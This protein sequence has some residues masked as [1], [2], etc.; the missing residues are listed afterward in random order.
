MI[1]K[2]ILFRI[3]EE[4]KDKFNL[5]INLRDKFKL[6]KKYLN[7]KE[8]LAIT[9]VRRCGKTYLMY[10]LMQDLV[11]TVPLK[12]ILY[13]NFED[14]RLAFIEVQDLD[15]IF[16]YYYEFSGAKGKL[17]LFFDEIQEVPMWEK[18]LSRSYE[19]HK[20]IISGSNSNLLSSELSSTITGRYIQLMIYPFSFKEFILGKYSLNKTEDIGHIKLKFNEYLLKGG[21]PE[22]L[23]YGKTDLLQEYYKSILLKDVISRYNIKHKSLLERLAVFIASNT[24]KPISLYSLNKQYDI[25]V[26]TIKNYLSY[27]E[28]SFLFINIKKFDYSLKKQQYNPVKIYGIDVA[29]MDSINFKFSKDIGRKLENVVLLELFN[30]NLEV[31]YHRNKIECD[32]VLK[33]GLKIIQAIQVCYELNKDNEKREL[34]GLMDALKNY[35]LKQG[36]ILTYDQERE[37]EIDGIKIIVK[38]IWKWLLE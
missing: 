5:K 11:K 34:N 29:L 9:G 15:K 2:N 27:L 16:E 25:S 24:G 4:S 7:Y 20:F 30:R 37:F 13:L 38:P 36:L 3:F 35:N 12:N 1:D 22:S 31:F 8:I 6:A 14:E 32:F 21:F 33:Q 18:W 19:Q 17:F 23:L 26:N 10:G 28:K